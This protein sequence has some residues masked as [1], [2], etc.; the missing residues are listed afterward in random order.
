[1]EPDKSYGTRIQLDSAHLYRQAR[2]ARSK[3]IGGLLST[4]CDA[5]IRGIR[6][7]HV[8]VAICLLCIVSGIAVIAI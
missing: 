6:S 2:A 1:M 8:N 7:G 5:T 3:Y 4:A